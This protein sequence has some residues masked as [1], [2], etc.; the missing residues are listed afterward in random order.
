MSTVLLLIEKKLVLR[1]EESRR[2]GGAGRGGAADRHV[3]C[4]GCAGGKR[5]GR[6][7]DARY[8]RNPS[9]AADW[10]PT[11]ITSAAAVLSQPRTG[12]NPRMDGWM[13]GGFFWLAPLLVFWKP[14]PWSERA[15]SQWWRGLTHPPIH[16]QPTRPAPPVSGEPQPAKAND[17][18]LGEWPSPCKG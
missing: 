12:I 14:K 9:L 4:G 3:T 11:P 13:G 1:H 16:I 6:P 8:R 10:L 7:P 17:P 5:K 2:R 18:L 15:G